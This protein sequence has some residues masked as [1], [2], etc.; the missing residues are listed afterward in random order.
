MKRWYFIDNG[1]L[2]TIR[3]DF[4]PLSQRN[5]VEMLWENY[6]ISERLKTQHYTR[7]QVKNYFWRTYD[8][9]EID[10]VEARESNLFAYEIKWSK[11][12]VKTPVAWEKAYPD[13]HFTVINRNNYRDFLEG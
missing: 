7:M 4:R 10:W 3:G 6:I 1:I 11:G 2:N 12:Q 8:Q 5:D 13:A 9:Q